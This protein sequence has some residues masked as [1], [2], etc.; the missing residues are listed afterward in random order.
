MAGEWQLTRL[1]SFDEIREEFIE[2]VHKTVWCNMATLDTRNRLRSRIVHPI[3]EGATGW[4]GTRQHSLKATHLAHHP[5]V[6]LAY[7]AD[8]SKP[9]YV[10][11]LAEW[12]EDYSSAST[13]AEMFGTDPLMHKKR[14]W[15]LFS[16]TPP[17]LGYDPA[18]IFHRVDD[19][20]FGLLRLTPFRIALMDIGGEAK[21][22]ES[23]DA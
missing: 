9:V 1:S 2:R 18:P 23:S 12:V 10:D 17:P 11:C 3:W 4:I 8:I 22:W 6:S 16:S 15:N 5:Y 14:I 7:I 21:M 20:D 13:A 19:P